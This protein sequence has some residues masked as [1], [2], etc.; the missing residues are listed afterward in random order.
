VPAPTPVAPPAA[1][2]KVKHRGRADRTV[3]VPEAAAEAKVAS[4]A[5]TPQSADPGLP[6]TARPA[7]VVAVRS[8]RQT[9]R[10]E[11]DRPLSRRERRRAAKI[12]AEQ[13]EEQ[14]RMERQMERDAKT[15]G[16]REREHVDW[17]KELV[18]VPVDPTLTTR[19]K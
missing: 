16:K 4:A 17:V 13:A 11:P 9:P 19:Q 7:E 8:S 3:R 18:N 12:A 14:A 10:E 5:V 1:P 6:R 2:K 15:M